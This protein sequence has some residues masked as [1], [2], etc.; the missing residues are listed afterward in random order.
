MA[1][2]K[3]F[4]L[5]STI[6]ALMSTTPHTYGGDFGSIGAAQPYGQAMFRIELALSLDRRDK[7]EISFNGIPLRSHTQSMNMTC[8]PPPESCAGLVTVMVVAGVASL[9][10]ISALARDR[11]R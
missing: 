8:P 10:L 7:P 4:L 9:A 11:D 2:T 3:R 6:V 5:I 1:D